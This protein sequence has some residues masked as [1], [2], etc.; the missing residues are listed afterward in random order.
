MKIYQVVASLNFGDAIGN[1]VVAK[2]HVIEDMGI[3]TEIYASGIA[4]KVTEPGAYLLDDM[5]KVKEDDIV[6]YHMGNGSPVNHMVTE[7][8]CR[9]IM[10]YHNITPYEFFGIDNITSSENCRV[11]LEDMRNHMKGK[12]DSYIADSEFNKSN[13][14]E[15]GYKAADIDVIPVIV[16]FDDY[17][18]EPDADM[19]RK[20][21]DGVTNILF[22]GRIAPNKKQED[23]IRAFAYYKEK[24]NPDSRLI[25]VGSHDANGMYYPDLVSYVEQ[26]GVED[27]IFP[28]HITFAEILAIYKTAHVFLCMSEHEGFCVPI[29][30]AMTFDVPIIAYNACAVPETIGGASVVVDDKDPVFLS[31]VIKEVTENQ[32]MRSM[33]IEAQRRRLEDFRYEKIKEDFQRYLRN[34]MDRFPPLSHDDRKKNY[35]KLYTLTEDNMKAAGDTMKFSRNALHTI[36]ARE[37]ENADITALINSD[38]SVKEFIEAAF[39]TFFNVMP[40]E[41]DYDFWEQE[42]QRTGRAVFMRTLINYARESQDRINKGVRFKY[43]PYSANSA[44]Q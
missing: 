5:P 32:E 24:V 42:E 36:A 35:D 7:L 3:E 30:E 44:E 31:K 13:M 4:S 15:M 22:V 28:G 19:V 33:I 11:G 34:F 20:L 2:K 9:R 12:F 38:C 18:Q 8:N 21:S 23:I 1:D 40:D 10:V 27:V 41:K 29:L 37:S 43:N 26:L 17:T 6:I 39:I 14:I 25:L 16:P